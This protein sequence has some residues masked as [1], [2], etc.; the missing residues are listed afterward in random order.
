MHITSIFNKIPHDKTIF[1]MLKLNLVCPSRN[2]THGYA[3][4]WVRNTPQYV[5]RWVHNQ[6]FS[7]ISNI[8]KHKATLCLAFKF[9][10]K[11]NIVKKL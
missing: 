2:S 3:P 1:V 7:R 10:P 8:T 5:P 4:I 6:Q 11:K 9:L